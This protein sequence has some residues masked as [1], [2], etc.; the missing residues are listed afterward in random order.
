MKPIPKTYIPSDIMMSTAKGIAT[1]MRLY[2]QLYQCRVCACHT[3]RRL[4]SLETNPF[5]AKLGNNF[6]NGRA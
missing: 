2:R 4:K 6:R 5:G 3:E 1:S